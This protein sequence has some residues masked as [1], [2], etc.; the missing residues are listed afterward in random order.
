[1]MPD[2][3]TH[4]LDAFEE[5]CLNII[6]D[7][8]E[9]IGVAYKG[10]DCGCA[11]ICGVSVSGQPLGPL[12]HVPGQAAICLPCKMDD[13]LKRRVVREG[14]YWPGDE[15]ER[16]DLELRNRIGRKVFGPGYGARNT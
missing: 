9:A 2:D 8:P 3:A 5:A 6:L 14:I 7:Y 1:M 11:L 16:P 10:L 13:G 4:P 12:T 15:T